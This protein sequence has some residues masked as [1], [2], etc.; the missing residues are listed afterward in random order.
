MY[1]VILRELQVTTVAAE[2]KKTYYVLSMCV[3]SLALANRQAKH[4]IPIILSSVACLAVMFFHVSH[5][6]HNFQRK[7]IEHKM[8]VLISTTFI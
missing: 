1:T 8:C 6:W 4:I 5:K 2:K 7:F 3:C